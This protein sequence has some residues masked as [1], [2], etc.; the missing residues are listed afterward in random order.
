MSSIARSI[1]PHS[2]RLFH[3][4]VI[5]YILFSVFCSLSLS[6]R[7]SVDIF[8]F[9]K[10]TCAMEQMK[11]GCEQREFFYISYELQIFIY[12]MLSNK[13]CVH[14]ACI[15]DIFFNIHYYIRPDGWIWWSGNGNGNGIGKICIYRITRMV[16]IVFNEIRNKLNGKCVYC[17]SDQCH[18]AAQSFRNAQ[19]MLSQSVDPVWMIKC[20]I[21]FTSS[22]VLFT[23]HVRWCFDSIWYI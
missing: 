19:H 20:K 13:V 1:P 2:L 18:C 14:C 3:S 10:W 21:E 7:R 6:F 11:I 16:N 4:P 12:G 8:S 9:G 15:G 17:L 23:I 5:Q 22:S